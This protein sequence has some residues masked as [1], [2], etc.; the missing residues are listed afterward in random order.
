MNPS[1]ITILADA[2]AI[3]P[4][5][6][7]LG[8]AAI[9]LV[10]GLLALV[11]AA[12]NI[13][14]VGARYLACLA[15]A[16]LVAGIVGAITQ[17]ESPQGETLCWILGLGVA[18]VAAV[19]GI[20]TVP[21][22]SMRIYQ[23]VVRDGGI[24]DADEW[25]LL[26][27]GARTVWPMIE[28]LIAEI[29]LGD[30][31]FDG[32]N[33]AQSMDKL[34]GKV[35][36]RFADGSAD[37]AF[38]FVGAPQAS[39]A[40]SHDDVDLDALEQFLRAVESKRPLSD[41]D[42]RV[43]RIGGQVQALM[44]QALEAIAAAYAALGSTAGGLQQAFVA[45]GYSNWVITQ[46]CQ[47][48]GLDRGTVEIE[49]TDIILSSDLEGTLSLRTQNRLSAQMA[50]E[51]IARAAMPSSADYRANLLQE[52]GRAIAKLSIEA[53]SDPEAQK[54]LR[55]LKVD[56]DAGALSPEFQKRAEGYDMQLGRF[57]AMAYQLAAAGVLDIDYIAAT[58]F[59]GDDPSA[60][61]RTALEAM[62]ALT[63]K[64]GK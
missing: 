33:P 4:V 6:F 53:E 15:S 46:L 32:G 56:H 58:G 38:R 52:Q 20:A 29:P 36:V 62:E 48:F 41:H 44:G 39:V 47:A 60:S 30:I 13:R 57:R 16:A 55:L 7:H 2:G 34:V 40:Q 12:Q 45:S 61:M 14:L 11:S 8:I 23:R 63:K 59:G 1:N 17:V 37:I 3:S 22:G 49:I 51:L 18:I 21:D 31:V 64:G 54:R 24:L 26:D 25:R 19:N 42:S 43:R 5:H 10:L 28:N 9:G 50:D 35:G 27:P